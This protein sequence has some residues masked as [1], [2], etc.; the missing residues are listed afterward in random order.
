MIARVL[1]EER[2][3]FRRDVRRELDMR[4]DLGAVVRALERGFVNPNR[5]RGH[6]DDE[7]GDGDE[8][9]WF[10]IPRAIVAHATPVCDRVNVS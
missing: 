6:A 4:P 2:G 7:R 3:A 1:D 8:G 9:L 5:D 10:T